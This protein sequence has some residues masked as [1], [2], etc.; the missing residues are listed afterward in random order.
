MP[1]TVDHRLHAHRRD[2]I[3]DAAADLV[4]TQGYADMSVQDVITRVGISKGAFYHYFGSKPALLEGLVERIAAELAGLC[5]EIV[6]DPTLPAGEKLRRCFLTM[7]RRKARMRPLLME[8][9]SVW[10]SDSN[11]VVRQKLCATSSGQLVPLM[12]RVIHEGVD[13]RVFSVSDPLTTAG[14]VWGLAQN[15]RESLGRLLL[16]QS[17]GDPLPAMRT[18]IAAYTEA[19]ERVLAMESGTLRLIDDAVV[20]GWVDSSL[21]RSR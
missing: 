18:R 1:R 4:A 19:I 14:I 21:G 8:M 11:A 7:T 12:A 6:D 9:L 3:L 13:E 15:L 20:A 10:Y 2:A 5:R 16:D 17:I